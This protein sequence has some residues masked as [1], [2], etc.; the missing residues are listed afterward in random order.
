[1][2]AVFLFLS[3]EGFH[4]HAALSAQQLRRVSKDKL[5][6]LRLANALQQVQIGQKRD[7]MILINLEALNVQK[8][9]HSWHS[10]SS[11]WFSSLIFV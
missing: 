2:R 9:G 5:W 11:S 7:V 10:N 8:H 6:Q 4:L 1:M 3:M